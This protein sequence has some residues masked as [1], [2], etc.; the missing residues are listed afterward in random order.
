MTDAE[1]TA[2]IERL[3]AREGGYVDHPNDVG[4]CT[5]MGIT[6]ETLEQH[7][8]KP[9][10]CADVRALHK[11]EAVAIYRR[12]WFSHKRL[13]L[14]Q[15]P[16]R[17][18]AEVTLDAAVMFSLG[19][20]MSAKWAQAGIN[21][22]RPAAA[23]LK[24]DGWAGP[25]TLAAMAMCDQHKLVSYVVAER[26]RKH[27]RVVKGSPSQAAFIEGWINRAT[28]WIMTPNGNSAEKLVPRVP[29]SEPLPVE[30]TPAIPDFGGLV[31]VRNRGK[32]LQYYTGYAFTGM[33]STEWPITHD[34]RAKALVFADQ[35]EI[36]AEREK[37]L[38]KLADFRS[39]PA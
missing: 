15:W 18:L 38:T 29:P 14:G 17:K 8:G 28:A 9:T 13:R 10:T 39:E 2:M 3:I 34:R 24:V 16:H 5:N 12:F 30:P 31:L 7:R 21:A 20:E 27:A 23:P 25:S 37:W 26:C 11:A 4:G 19:R 35:D 36:A 22:L 1:I 33:S 6:R 32:D